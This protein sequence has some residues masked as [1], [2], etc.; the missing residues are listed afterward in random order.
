MTTKNVI[1][2]IIIFLAALGG[3]EM[4]QK[5]TTLAGGINGGDNATACTLKSAASV[6]VG[7][8]LSTVVLPANARRAWA[9]VEPISTANIVGVIL[10]STATTT[11]VNSMFVGTA[12]SSVLTLGLNTDL[13]YAGDVQVITNNSSTTVRV[14]ECTY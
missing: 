1:I 5:P 4:K 8:Q 12:S 7:N 10:G 6:S 14:T 3:Y 9:I 13:P 2:G 11:S